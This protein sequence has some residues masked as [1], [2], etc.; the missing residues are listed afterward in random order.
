M[1]RVFSQFDRS[2]LGSRRLTH[3]SPV[4]IGS[5]KR[6]RKHTNDAAEE[7]FSFQY[8]SQL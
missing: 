6:S 1:T 7:Q 2:N 4:L 5:G 8:L 3:I